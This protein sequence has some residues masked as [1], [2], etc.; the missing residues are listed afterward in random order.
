MGLICEYL[1]RSSGQAVLLKTGSSSRNIREAPEEEKS[2][3]ALD[4]DCYWQFS[5]TRYSVHCSRYA[6]QVSVL[7]QERWV[8]EQILLQYLF[9]SP[10]GPQFWDDLRA[11]CRE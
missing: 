8:G 11:R 10:L 7:F 9:H 2:N 6:T 4:S 3:V 1:S 5:G